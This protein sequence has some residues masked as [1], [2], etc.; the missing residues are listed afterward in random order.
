[1][2]RRALMRGAAAGPLLLLALV[3]ACATLG[4]ADPG[5]DPARVRVL[6]DLAEDRSLFN[7][8]DDTTPYTSWDWGLYLVQG[9][10]NVPLRPDPPQ[11]LKVIHAPRLVRDTVFLAPPGRHTLRLIVQGSVGLREGRIYWPITT[12]LVNQTFTLDL[13]AG[14]GTTLRPTRVHSNKRG[15]LVDPYSVPGEPGR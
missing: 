1:M 5:P 6:V 2:V 14:S 15:N 3:A 7:V 13:Q 11:Q 8:F 9:G 12:V 4:T 10:R